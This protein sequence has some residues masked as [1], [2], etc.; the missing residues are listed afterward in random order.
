[1]TCEPAGPDSNAPMA[2]AVTRPKSVTRIVAVFSLF[3]CMALGTGARIGA[4][5]SGDDVVRLRPMPDYGTGSFADPGVAVPDDP[6]LPD[7]TSPYGELPP[8]QR[9]YDPLT[10]HKENKALALNLGLIVGYGIYGRF[11][12][13]WYDT[14]FFVDEE[15]WFGKNT[16]FGG[17]DK[18]GHA[19]T[20]YGM[21][22][23][24]TEIYDYWGFP[25]D[26]A[27]WWGVGSSILHTTLIEVGDGLSPEN[28]FAPEDAIV[29][30]AGALFF[31]ARRQWPRVGEVVDFRWEYF[32]SETFRKGRVRD[33]LTD[34]SGSK[35]VLAWKPDGIFRTDSWLKYLEIHTGYFTRGFAKEDKEFF[36]E[37]DRT[38]YVGVG[39]SVTELVGIFTDHPAK[40]V[41][42]YYQVPYT[43]LPYERDY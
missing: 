28:G 6:V 24:F 25:E 32:P 36:P 1:M 29:N 37:E 30:V 13:D 16:K 23:V 8:D 7:A 40:N 19:F 18:L 14:S 5:E 3:S 10:W 34:Y 26:E 38:W 15:G 12:W 41:F 42:N 4:E 20:S 43:Y 22:L 11:A 31:L 21:A 27:L 39:V 35:Y 33:P 9:W 17:A 2:L